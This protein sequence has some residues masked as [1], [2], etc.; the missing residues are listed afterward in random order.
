MKKEKKRAVCS[1][2]NGLVRFVLIDDL[3]NE[4]ELPIKEYLEF[5]EEAG[6]KSYCHSFLRNGAELTPYLLNNGYECLPVKEAFGKKKKKYKR[7]DDDNGLVVKVEVRVNKKNVSFYDSKRI[8]NFSEEALAKAFELE[9]NDLKIVAESLAIMIAEGHDKNSISACAFQSFLDMKFTS[10]H[11]SQRNMFRRV[12]PKLDDQCEELVRRAYRGG[13]VY[14][15]PEHKDKRG[16]KGCAYDVNSLF[17]DIMATEALPLYAP[18]PFEG[19]YQFDIY[20]PLFIQ[21]I[22][23][24]WVKLKPGKVP[25]LT[26]DF[27]LDKVVEDD[28]IVKRTKPT[29]TVLTNMEL[30]L[31]KECYD[32]GVITYGKGYKFKASQVVFK[33]YVEY[34]GD[35]KQTETGAKRQIAKLFLNSL[36]GKFGSKSKFKN[37]S[38]KLNEEG[39][40]EK[41]FHD[42]YTDDNLLSYVPVSAFITAYARVRTIKA[43]NANYK[44]FIYADTDSIHLIGSEVNGIELHETELGKWKLEKRFTDSK[45]LNIKCYAEKDSKGWEFK[46][47]GLPKDARL[48]IDNFKFGSKVDYECCVRT[49]TG[50]AIVKRQ[51]EIGKNELGKSIFK[52]TVK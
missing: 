3:T 5:C 17:P 9:G 34:W 15:N 7:I 1:I 49:K 19:E 14:L 22:T 10:K 39:I 40:E 18:I 38:F 50:S 37:I 12:Y 11:Y 26:S 4:Y 51:F 2:K 13:W 29:R 6:I 44:N 52:D 47:A 46:V 30:E 27:L 42:Y 43:A 31:F 48:S 8:L 35:K 41:V 32:Y 20:H 28:Y 33:E 24:D 45:F 21:E 16:L 36:Y 23:V 25:F